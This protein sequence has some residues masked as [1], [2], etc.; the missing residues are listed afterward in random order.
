MRSEV[1]RPPPFQRPRA[2]LYAG[3]L[4]L[5]SLLSGCASYILGEPAGSGTRALASQ[6]QALQADSSPE[7]AARYI[8][9]GVALNDRQTVFD[10]DIRLLDRTLA[11]TYG[12]AYRSVLLSNRR[13]TE[14]PRD[15]PLATIDHLDEVF[16]FLAQHK[17]SQDR[18]IVLLSSHGTPGMLEVSQFP[19]YPN[20]RLLAAKKLGQWMETLEPNLSWLMISACYSGSHLER[21]K[22]D[23]L[24]V[25]TAAS[26]K[27]ASF[28]CANDQVNTWFVKELTEAM[29]PQQNFKD[30]WQA[31]LARIAERE[32]QKKLPQSLPQMSVGSQW[33]ERINEDW[34]RF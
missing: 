21:L 5:S 14:G 3:L 16:D 29:R 28:G 26:A 10:A 33:K 32:K 11:T 31:S 18:F 15:L 23:H 24:L 2:L 20:A 34:T 8:F 19:L 25:M 13:I 22:Q 4:A 6:L 1:K 9:V 7:S 30:W 12:P 17:R 27:T